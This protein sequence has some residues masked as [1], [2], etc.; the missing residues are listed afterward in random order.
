[1]S[2]NL[3]FIGGIHGVGKTTFSTELSKHL[4]IPIYTASEI[5]DKTIIN[6]RIMQNKVQD[7]QKLLIEGLSV[8]TKDTDIILD[9]HFVLFSHDNNPIKIPLDTFRDL[10]P[11]L[12]FILTDAPEKIYERLLERDNIHYSLEVLE[13]LQTSEISYAHIVSNV[14]NI[15]LYVVKKDEKDIIMN[16]IKNYRK[17]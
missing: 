12:M 1:M 11:K 15:P 14:L 4:D 5:I 3:F 16:I 2:K 7:N 8:L 9:G 13:K 10:S 17:I 6:K